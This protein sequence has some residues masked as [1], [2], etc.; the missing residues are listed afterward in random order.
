MKQFISRFASH[1]PVSFIRSISSRI[2]TLRFD[3]KFVHR[4][5]FADEVDVPDDFPEEAKPLTYDINMATFI[6]MKPQTFAAI[7]LYRQFRQ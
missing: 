5:A 7:Q 1:F 2:I 6:R 4:I 3:V